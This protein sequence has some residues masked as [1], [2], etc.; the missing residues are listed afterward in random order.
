MGEDNMLEK[1]KFEARNPKNQKPGHPRVVTRHFGCGP[2][3]RLSFLPAHLITLDGLAE[4]FQGER[5]L[6]LAEGRQFRRVALQIGI[7]LRANED[8]ATTGSPF[9]AA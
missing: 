4:T 7:S 8:A 2:G 1:P 6:R 9:Q 5:G 3:S